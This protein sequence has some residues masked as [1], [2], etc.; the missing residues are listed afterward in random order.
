MPRGWNPETED[1]LTLWVTALGNRDQQFLGGSAASP[2]AAQGGASGL[3]QA[4]WS[5]RAAGEAQLSPRFGGK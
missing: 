5:R 2:K 1:S 3:S 4:G